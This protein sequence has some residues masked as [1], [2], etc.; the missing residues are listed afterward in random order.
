MSGATSAWQPMA[1]GQREEPSESARSSPDECAGGYL[2]LRFP[3]AGPNHAPENARATSEL[4]ALFG[5]RST[6]R[7]FISS[8]SSI[9][10]R[11][12][13]RL[14]APATTKSRS[15]KRISTSMSSSTRDDEII[16]PSRRS[17]L[18]SRNSRNSSVAGCVVTACT[19]T[20]GYRRD[21]RSIMADVT[22]ASDSGHQIRTSPA[23]GFAR[24]SMSLIPCLNSSNT[25]CPRLSSAS[26]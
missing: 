5:G 9:F 11:R 20:P 19:T 12:A 2:L 18:R 24:N 14:R 15:S 16:L 21:N 8:A 17:T 10:W 4:S 22:G 6:Q 23:T 25:T 3:G 26:A 13:H 1:T 7:S